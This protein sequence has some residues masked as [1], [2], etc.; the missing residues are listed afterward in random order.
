MFRNLKVQPNCAAL[1][2][3][4]QR[5][6]TFNRSIDAFNAELERVGTPVR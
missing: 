4:K 3:L 2:Q 6:D 1:E 5:I